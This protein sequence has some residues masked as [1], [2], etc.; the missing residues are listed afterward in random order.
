MNKVEYPK[1]KFDESSSHL[2]G[3]L[4]TKNPFYRYTDPRKIKGCSFF[5]GVDWEKLRAKEYNKPI[6]KPP[7]FDFT[8]KLEPGDS[9]GG[10][11]IQMTTEGSGGDEDLQ[12]NYFAREGLQNPN[13]D[14]IQWLI[15]QK[16]AV[17]CCSWLGYGRHQCN[18]DPYPPEKNIGV[19]IQ[20]RCKAIY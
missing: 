16:K 1:E 14:Y 18:G 11:A 7:E 20:E 9:F 15:D 2:I 13:S 5:E 8:E 3:K 6:W 12:F 10:D 17:P 19:P 4:L